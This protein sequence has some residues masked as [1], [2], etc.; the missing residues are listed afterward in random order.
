MHIHA[1]DLAS[2]H[3]WNN[4]PAHQARSSSLD[5]DVN[6]GRIVSQ[7]ARGISQPSSSEAPGVSNVET[8]TGTTGSNADGSLDDRSGAQSATSS[9]SSI[10]GP[11]SPSAEITSTIDV[12]V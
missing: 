9:S 3:G 4:S 10:T 8:G 1:N 7:I 2:A 6:F 11:A 12:S 5:P